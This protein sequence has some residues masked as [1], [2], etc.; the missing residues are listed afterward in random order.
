MKATPRFSKKQN[1]FTLPEIIVVV[2][3]VGI[4]LAIAVRALSGGTDSANSAAIRN[5]AKAL[6]NAVGYIHI[7]L[8][9]GIITSGNPIAQADMMDVLMIGPTMVQAQYQDAYKG[10]NMRPLETDIKV[11]AR[12]SGSTTG[13]YEL[14]TYPIKFAAT[15]DADKVCVQYDHVTTAVVKE[16]SSKYGIQYTDAG[17]TTSALSYTAPSAGFHTVTIMNV[18]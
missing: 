5:S 14:L 8:G 6:A 11:K 12:P 9:N 15:C 7:N 13:S 4:L 17:V 3:L 1:G 16:I 18:P 10:L 2:V